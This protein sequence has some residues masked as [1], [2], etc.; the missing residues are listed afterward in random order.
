MSGT[1]KFQLVKAGQMLD[2]PR[3]TNETSVHTQTH[4]PY[5]EKRSGGRG[6]GGERKRESETLQMQEVVLGHILEA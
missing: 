2:H 1:G 3:T 5:Q 6:A 4:T